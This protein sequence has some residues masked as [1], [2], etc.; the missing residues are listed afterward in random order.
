[1]GEFVRVALLSELNEGSLKKVTVNSTRLLLAKVRGQVYAASL[2]CPH[3]GADLSEG[4]LHGTVL[5]CPL[6][7]SQFDLRD[8]RVVRWTDLKGAV[9]TYA[10][11]ARPP[12]SLKC[13]P[14]R[15]EEDTVLV[16]IP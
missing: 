11:K 7:N 10:T 8:G 9:L 14:V 2:L 3:L 15:V 13:Y 1:M 5:T 16:S 12:R 4:T 6:H